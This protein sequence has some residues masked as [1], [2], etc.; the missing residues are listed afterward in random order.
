MMNYCVVRKWLRSSLFYDI[1]L[2]YGVQCTRYFLPLVQVPFLA[3]VLEPTGWGAMAFAQGFSAYL[4]LIVEYGF[5]LSA[6]REIAG[7]LHAPERIRGD[8]RQVR[9]WCRRL[10]CRSQHIGLFVSR[11][12]SEA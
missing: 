7:A 4:M 8:G 10:V 5:N 9:T 12:T 3:R 1:A 2:L 6:T 11:T